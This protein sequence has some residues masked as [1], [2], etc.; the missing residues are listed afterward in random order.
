MIE[1]PDLICSAGCT[2]ARP[3]DTDEPSLRQP[4]NGIRVV[5]RVTTSRAAYVV[6]HAGRPCAHDRQVR[7]DHRLYDLAS[8]SH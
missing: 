4:I 1:Y 6:L 8:R 2:P 5:G 7:P 3:S